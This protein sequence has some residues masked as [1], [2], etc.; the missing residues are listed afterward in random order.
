MFP[1][2]GFQLNLTLIHKSLEIGNIFWKP[3]RGKKKRLSPESKPSAPKILYKGNN[4]SNV[5]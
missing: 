2:Q 1:T 5:A 4:L 3:S